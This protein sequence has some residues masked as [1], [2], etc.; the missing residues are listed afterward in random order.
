MG[1]LVRQPRYPDAAADPAR[2]ERQILQPDIGD[3]DLAFD[4]RRVDPKRCPNDGRPARH[5]NRRSRRS[6]CRRRMRRAGRANRPAA[7]TE[8]SPPRSAA[9]D[10][11]PTTAGTAKD[12]GDAERRQAHG[13]RGA[14]LDCQPS[15]GPRNGCKDCHPPDATVLRQIGQCQPLP[16]GAASATQTGR[17]AFEPCRIKSIARPLVAGRPRPSGARERWSDA[18]CRPSPSAG[19]SS[20]TPEP[21]PIC[22]LS[23]S[24]STCC[25]LGRAYE[26]VHGPS[27]YPD[28][29]RRRR[30]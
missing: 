14:R 21:M 5:R 24:S 15:F 11:R 10:L 22:A 1:I 12:G 6:S 26:R 25:G 4:E 19:T 3:R 8:R 18:S 7:G 27:R 30:P 23:K 28:R 20:S 13:P 17:S 29:L 9:I 16:V 2:F